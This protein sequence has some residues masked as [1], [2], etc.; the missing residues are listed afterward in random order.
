MRS[1]SYLHLF[2]TPESIR[3]RK[4]AKLL[5]VLRAKARLLLGEGKV[6]PYPAEEE[7]YLV[8]PIV[9]MVTKHKG[10][11]TCNCPRFKKLGICED[12]LAVKRLEDGIK[13]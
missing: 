11:W 2:E 8:Y 1:I 3:R 6:V 10:V 12:V 9:F 13:G 5:R 7:M 4:R